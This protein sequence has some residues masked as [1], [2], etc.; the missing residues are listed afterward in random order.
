MKV[1][2]ELAIVVGMHILEYASIHRGAT[3]VSDRIEFIQ[4]RMPVDLDL[5]VPVILS[6]LHLIDVRLPE[7]VGEVK[8]QL[9]DSG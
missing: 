4:H 3:R 6:V 5:K 7:W 2:V 9:I 1:E 8:P